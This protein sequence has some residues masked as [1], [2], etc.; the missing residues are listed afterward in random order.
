MALIAS[1]IAMWTMAMAR[2]ARPGPELFAEGAMFAG[3]N[4]GVIQTGSVD[5]DLV[6]AVRR[7]HSQHLAMLLA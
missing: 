1:K 3:S 5:R 7:H 4:R 2:L 6:P